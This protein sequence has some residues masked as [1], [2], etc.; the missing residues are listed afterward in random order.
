[1][2]RPL[3]VSARLR[4]LYCLKPIIKYSFKNV[5]DLFLTLEVKLMA[6]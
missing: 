6:V 5:G 2:A 1:M 3:R 4:R